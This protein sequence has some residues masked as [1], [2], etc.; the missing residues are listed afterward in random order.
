MKPGPISG[1]V[2]WLAGLPVLLLWHRCGLKRRY[3]P[4]VL[5]VGLIASIGLAAVGNAPVLAQDGGGQGGVEEGLIDVELGDGGGLAYPVLGSRLS[6]LADQAAADRLGGVPATPHVP[7]GTGN[8]SD[9][10]NYAV[11]MIGLSITFDGDSERVIEAITAIG[12]DVRNVFDGYVEALVPPAALA[13]LAQIPSLT[14]ARE[15]AVPHKNR[16][17][18]T[19]GGVA[20]HLASAWHRAGF[21]GGGVK[22]GVIDGSSGTT[23]RDGFWGLRFDDNTPEANE[24]FKLVLYTPAQAKIT[25]NE[26]TGTITDND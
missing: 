3:L 16:G 17:R 6:A 26:A 4:A 18:A 1:R 25:D 14:W 10:G 5:V 23:T 20:A 22:I 8:S 11:S 9:A 7:G 15:F 19:S 12:G 2:G 13:A 24:T 21:T